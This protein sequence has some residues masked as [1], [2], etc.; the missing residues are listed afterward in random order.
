MAKFGSDIIEIGSLGL[1]KDPFGI[2][3]AEDAAINASNIQAEAG[4]EAIAF[5]RESL[6]QIR[7]DLQPFRQAGTDTLPLLQQAID[8]PSGRVI[9]NPFFQALAGDQ[10]QRILNQRA[11][12]GLA[13]SGGTDDALARAQLLLG[14]QFAQQD[15]GN[16]TNLTTIGQNAAAQTGSATQQTATGVSNLLTDV[17]NVQAAGLIGEANVQQQF[18]SDLLGAGATIGGAIIGRP[19]A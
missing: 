7:G 5:Q 4:Q 15:I 9:N 12:L 16:L 1:V 19:R 2:D 6:E 10:E 17:G 14:N 13:G 8:D 3:A 11:S 18:N